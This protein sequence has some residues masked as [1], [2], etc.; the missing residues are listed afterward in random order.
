M[1]R[2]GE[3]SIG[4]S[5]LSFGRKLR[6]LPAKDASFAIAIT[7]G[8]NP[9]RRLVGAVSRLM[10]RAG[11]HQSSLPG[12]ILGRAVAIPT[13]TYVGEKKQVR[14]QA[15]QLPVGSFVIVAA[16]RFSAMLWNIAGRMV[17]KG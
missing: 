5:H 4:S 14:D 2:L 17:S 1:R 12:P 13:L 15:G 11:E 16:A 3:A 9:V 8:R 6:Y 7:P 10:R